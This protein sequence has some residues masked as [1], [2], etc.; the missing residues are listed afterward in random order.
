[1]APLS[2]QRYSFIQKR[3]LPWARPSERESGRI[4]QR[5]APLR[6]LE[7]EEVTSAL[8]VRGAGRWGGR[9][10]QGRG[11]PPHLVPFLQD[12]LCSSELCAFV[13]G[14]VSPASAPLQ[15]VVIVAAPF[16]PGLPLMSGTQKSHFLSENGVPQ[17]P[18]SAPSAQL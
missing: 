4:H 10:R 17:N 1:M 7:G 11:L 18:D 5:V 2:P 13:S 15:A 12:L 9:D 6:T 3:P 16:I 8:W 14:L